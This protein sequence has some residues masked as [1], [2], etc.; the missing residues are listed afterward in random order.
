M[1]AWIYPAVFLLSFLIYSPTLQYEFVLDDDLVCAKNKYVQ[2]GI[3]G[4]PGCFTHSWYFGFTGTLDRYYRPLMLSSLALDRSILGASPAGFHFSNVCLFALFNMLLFYLLLQMFGKKNWLLA[5]M[6]TGIFIVHPI[7]SE[8]VAN[9]KSRDE[10]LAYGALMGMLIMLFKHFKKPNGIFL[11]LSMCFYGTAMLSKESAFAFLG[12]VP[13]FMYFFSFD[14]FRKIISITVGYLGI[15]VIILYIRSLYTDPNPKDF[16]IID[17]SLIAI[18]NPVSQFSTAISM[19]GK[20]FYMLVFPFRLSYDYSFDQIPAI[21]Y[22]HY[23]SLTSWAL[24][25]GLTWFVIKQLPKRHIAALGIL[26]FGMC[27]SITSNVFFL[28]GSSFAERFMFIP[29]IGFCIVAG[30]L[31]TNLIRQSDSVQ[32]IAG[33][34]I[35]ILIFTSFS[36]TL[37]KRLPDWKS[38]Q[39]LFESGIRTAPNS[40][41]TQSFYGKSL[42]DRALVVSDPSIKRVNLEKS[43]VHFKKSIE[44][45]PGFS[46][47][48]LHL[49]AAYEQNNQLEMAEETYINGFQSDSTY[50]PALVNL[51]V[52]YLKKERLAEGITVLEQAD[53]L[54]PDYIIIQKNLGIA[55]LHA[56]QIDNAIPLFE[57]VLKKEYNI[58]NL[59]SLV[60][61]YRVKGDIDKA[62]SYDLEIKRLM[63]LEK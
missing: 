45:H 11:F 25:A 35:S 60:Q 47:T 31:L 27:F 23:K 43:I 29:S 54:K 8:V 3:E 10:L 49:A 5:I 41:R 50:Y 58:P 63:Q 39:H 62:I 15:A 18:N 2:S 21:P 37:L 53:A 42:Y 51:G 40:A 38:D 33:V 19:L 7:H 24:L 17:N 6:I 32:R 59:S 30:S 16:S 4:I 26:F 14:G 52:L 22:Y 46:E 61:A 13:L 34:L 57:K 36:F 56:G 20:Y 28:T 55:Y 48:Y 12:L 1:F 44:I 9:I